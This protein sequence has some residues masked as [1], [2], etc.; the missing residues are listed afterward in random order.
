MPGRKSLPT[1]E[2]QLSARLKN[3]IEQ[4]YPELGSVP[5]PEVAVPREEGFGDYSANVALT[6]S[7]QLKRP[8]REV[9]EK[10]VVALGD[11][12]GL[13][14]EVSVAGPGFLNLSLSRA[15]LTGALEEALRLG[16]A[17][18]RSA[19]G[20]GLKVQVEFVSANPTGPLN[21]VNA[22]AAAFGGTLARLLN[23][24][25]FEAATEFYVNDVG[26]QIDRLGESFL[27]RYREAKGMGPAVIPENGYK[28]A[29]LADLAGQLPDASVPA[30]WD[31]A[32]PG[33]ETA[34]RF[35]RLAVERMLAWQEKDLRAY[36]TT[37]DRWYLQSEL[38]PEAIRKTLDLIREKGF[39]EEKEGALW[40]TTTRFGD[41][42]DRVLVRSNGEPTYF[43]ADLAYHADKYAR[44]FRRVIDI[45][46]PDHHGHIPRMQAGMEI[47]G[48]GK[49]WLE[50]IIVQQVNLLSGGQPVKMS[51]REGE[52]VTLDDLVREVG[53]DTAIFFFL[54]R[55][56]NSHLDFDL[57]LARSTSD[58]NPVY[59]VKY[60]HARIS[61]ILRVAAERGTSGA[62]NPAGGDPTHLVHPTELT[63]MR[64]IAQF[65]D[66]IRGAAEAREP[67][68]LAT[69]VRKLSAAFHPFYHQ[70]RV[71]GEETN[72]AHARLLLCAATR[73]TLANGLALM[74]IEAP[75]TM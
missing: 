40:L 26:N 10:L 44:G 31:S 51:K 52:F 32:E 47:M 42:Q 61:G 49:E 36:G 73:Q 41:D 67:H 18:G 45:W 74:N 27:A 39:T 29:Y 69:Y 17:F 9:A 53:K 71:V 33:A 2:E 54:M 7:K 8:P 22:R 64:L 48:F 4:T 58:E 20:A 13:V 57:D 12:G 50:V 16:P 63:L 46:G 11:A 62:D 72:L 5:A 37:Y 19:G 24:A 25:G 60:A 1:I 23:A 3:A 14:A 15:A 35:S 38:Y 43:L 30:G 28:G 70:C 59:Y 21:V 6:L 66:L 68:R 65:P 75:E 56:A 34:G 55:R